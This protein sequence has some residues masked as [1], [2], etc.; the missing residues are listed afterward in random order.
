MSTFRQKCRDTF[1]MHTLTSDPDSKAS[2]KREIILDAELMACA[3]PSESQEESQFQASAAI[4]FSTGSAK[5]SGLL[6]MADNTTNGRFAINE[7]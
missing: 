6:F 4:S 3:T 1:R 5:Y 7:A 2:L